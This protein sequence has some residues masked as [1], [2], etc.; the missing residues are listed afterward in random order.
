MEI[1][2]IH[3][4]V[5][6]KANHYQAV[7]GYTGR[8]IIK[9]SVIRAYERSFFSQCRIY[10]G[11]G[12]DSPFELFIKVFQSSTRY[13]LDNSLKTILDC[14]EMVGAITDDNLCYRIEA[15]KFIDKSRPR[16]EYGL[17]TK[18]QY[19]TFNNQ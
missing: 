1:E 16:I 8:R 10:K 5:P 13:D 12:V 19:L 3:G 6:A 7:G 9:D 2:I 14:L 4:Q 18:Q 15:L 11:R 17:L